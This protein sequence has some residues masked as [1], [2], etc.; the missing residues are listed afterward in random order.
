MIHPE[1]RTVKSQWIN[2]LQLHGMALRSVDHFNSGACY[3]QQSVKYKKNL[4]KIKKMK[5]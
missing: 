1:V 5:M 2:N 4:A 3:A